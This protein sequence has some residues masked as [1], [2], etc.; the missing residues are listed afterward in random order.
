MTEITNTNASFVKQLSVGDNVG[1]EE[2]S[3]IFISRYEDGLHSEREVVSQRI[4]NLKEDLKK[5]EATVVEDLNLAQYD[6]DVPVLNS[7]TRASAQVDWKESNSCVEIVLY[8]NITEC[9][10][11]RHRLFFPIPIVAVHQYNTIEKSIEDE[12][13]VLTDIISK[14][15]DISRKER[16]IRSKISEMKLR[17]MGVDNILESKELLKLIDLS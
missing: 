17:E 10:S 6:T 5:L 9:W 15:K 2:V 12:T 14:I 3:N 4:K 1:I 16:S 8:T 11:A 7:H 13:K